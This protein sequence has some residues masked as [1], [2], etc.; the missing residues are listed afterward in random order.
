MKTRALMSIASANEDHDHVISLMRYRTLQE[1][2]QRV[3]HSDIGRCNVIDFNEYLLLSFVFYST[4]TI[5]STSEKVK[6]IS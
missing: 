3:V 5:V 1:A 6:V 2:A 4:L